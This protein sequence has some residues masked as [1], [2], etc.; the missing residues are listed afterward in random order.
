MSVII[1]T[2]E[3]FKKM[4]KAGCLAAEI[5]D[6]IGDFVRPGI[7]TN[8]LNDLCHNKIIE[9]DAIPAP[10]NY[11][12]FPK[13]V[14]TSINHVICHGIPSDKKLKN[15]DMINIDV[16]VIIDGWHGDTSRTYYAGK[17]S[18]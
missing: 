16:T 18:N 14:C 9:N 10:L 1:H 3:D 17:T 5:L 13:S 7:T 15:G 4:R 2:E 8:E 12:G 11:K 6:Y